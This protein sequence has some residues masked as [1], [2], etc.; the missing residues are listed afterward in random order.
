MTVDKVMYLIIDFGCYV[1]R[2]SIIISPFDLI[3]ALI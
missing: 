1:T 3:H 2:D